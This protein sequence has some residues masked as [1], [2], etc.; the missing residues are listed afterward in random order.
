MV[1]NSPLVKNQKKHKSKKKSKSPTLQKIK[2]KNSQNGF[3]VNLGKLPNGKGID[4]SCKNPNLV[5][6]ESLLEKLNDNAPLR[7]F[8]KKELGIEPPSTLGYTPIF[9]TPEHHII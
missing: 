4:F 8:T 6:N 1:Q 5:V 7:K 2:N 9:K 3:T